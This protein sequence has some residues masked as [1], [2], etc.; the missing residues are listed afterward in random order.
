MTC[1]VVSCRVTSNGDVTSWLPKFFTITVTLAVLPCT[2]ELG[3]LTLIT[4]RSVSGP[5]GGGAKPSIVTPNRLSTRS[6][7]LAMVTVAL[8]AKSSA[9]GLRFASSVTMS[10]PESPPPLKP[11]GEMIS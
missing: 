6:M 3:P 5:G 2:T 8:P 9:T 4:A 11:P 7:R 10:E 1:A